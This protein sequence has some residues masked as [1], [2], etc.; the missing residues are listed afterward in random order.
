MRNASPSSAASG[1]AGSTPEFGRLAPAGP[2]EGLIRAARG[3]GAGWA[4]MRRAFAL[5][6]VAQKMARGGALDVETFGV[7]MRLRACDNSCEKRLLYT[8]HYFD[9]QE[10][11]ILAARLPQ[12][13]VFVDI[14][15]NV[16]GYALFV[17]ALADRGARVIAIEP[18]REM[19]ERLAFNSRASGLG[20]VRV[21]ECAVADRTGEATLFVDPR[22]RA[23]ASIRVLVGDGSREARRVPTSTL[24]KILQDEGLSRLDALKIDTAG[25]DDL[26]LD[27][28]FAQAPRSAWPAL[29]IVDATGLDSAA[30]ADRLRASGY[31]DV[32]RTRLNF[33][34]ELRVSS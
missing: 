6:A 33:V 21:I 8:P 26:A 20:G 31:R 5:R 11:A 18:Q 28:F 27:P 9:P 34:F 4:G 10:R 7:R 30:L 3:C 13:G 25:G 22:D 15:A 12:G 23:R 16:G 24:L 32:L 1:D 14:G 19:C 17:A 2:I 29:L